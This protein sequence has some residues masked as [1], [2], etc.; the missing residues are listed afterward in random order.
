V[1]L[2]PNHDDTL[3]L[4]YISNVEPVEI[5]PAN[6]NSRLTANSLISYNAGNLCL[7]INLTCTSTDNWLIRAHLYQDDTSLTGSGSREQPADKICGWKYL[8]DRMGRHKK[9]RSVCLVPKNPSP[10]CTSQ[11]GEFWE[12]FRGF[13]LNDHPY[14]CG[15][16][17]TRWCTER[18]RG[19]LDRKEKSGWKGE[20]RTAT[21]F[22]NNRWPKRVE[23]SSAYWAAS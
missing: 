4:L 19:A 10:E 20:Q 5:Y 8:T 18:E 3:L 14:K 9:S 22:D 17:C 1:W 23:Q 11:A 15:V 6:S 12:S 7:F 2:T 21:T 13:S 16:V